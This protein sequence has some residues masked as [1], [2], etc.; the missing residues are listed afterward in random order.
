MYNT[1]EALAYT[2]KL[3]MQ[4]AAITPQLLDLLAMQKVEADKKAAAQQLAMA[5]GQPQPTIAQ[6]LQQRAMQSARQEI[7]Q[8]MGLGDL[9]QAQPPAGPMPQK[10]Q[11]LAGAPTNLPTEYRGGGIIA[12]AQGGSGGDAHGRY[13]QQDAEGQDVVQEAAPAYSQQQAN[14]DQGPQMSAEDKAFIQAERAAVEKLRNQDP[15]AEAQKAMEFQQKMLG[16]N[17]DAAIDHKRE[18]KAGL[19]ALFDRQ[20]AER[21]SDLR[22]VLDRMAQNIREPGG[23]GAA[24]FGVSQAGQAA[25]EGYTKQ[26]IAQL[27]TLSLI[28]DEIDKAIENNDLSKYNAFVSRKKEIE[29]QIEKG[30]QTGATMADV[31]ERVLQ[32]KQMNFNTVEGRKQAAATLAQQRADALATQD[33]TR[34]LG[35]ETVDATRRVGLAQAAATV[36]A[37]RQ[38]RAGSTEAAREANLFKLRLDAYEKAA[39]QVA[40]NPTLAY[41]SEDIQQAAIKKLASSMIKDAMEK[42]EAAGSDIS[43]LAAQELARRQGQKRTLTGAR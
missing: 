18:Q 12:F 14:E 16:P 32:G 7:A 42:P 15:E 38:A 30:V 25:R 27:N 1:R 43:S 34:R 9:A 20:M 19:K 3:P 17:R 21:P 8:K 11:G 33:A 26:E 31:L 40:S 37:A 13:R 4:Q 24:M 41:Q 39:K 35:I 10:P 5:S 23:Y 28:D 6:G 2:G 36:E 29:G 22:V